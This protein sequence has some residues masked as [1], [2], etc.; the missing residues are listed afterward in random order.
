VAVPVTAAVR[1]ATPA[2]AEAIARVHV[3]SFHAAY[4]GRMPAVVI[5]AFTLEKRVARWRDILARDAPEERSFVSPAEGR[6]IGFASTGP[7]RDADAAPG[8]AELYA[9]YLDPAA[10][11]LGIGRALFAEAVADLRARGRV[12]MTAWVLE[13]NARAQ[14]FY[15]ACGMRLDGERKVVVEEGADLV[16][17]RHALPIA[18]RAA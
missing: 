9:L 13:G 10:W 18:A 7:A 5:A 4:A 16:H 6:V 3:A 15:E 17:V 14:R 1:L 2:D 8:T 11:G 12:A